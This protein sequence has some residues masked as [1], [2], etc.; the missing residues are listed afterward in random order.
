MFVCLASDAIV[1]LEYNATQHAIVLQIL[2]NSIQISHFFHN[3]IRTAV[4]LSS[5]LARLICGGERTNLSSTK[6]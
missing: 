4:Q 2:Y 5:E 6:I 3:K 1:Q